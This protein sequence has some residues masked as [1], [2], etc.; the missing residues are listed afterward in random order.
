VHGIGINSSVT[1]A[2]AMSSDATGASAD[3]AKQFTVNDVHKVS[4]ACAAS[5]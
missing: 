1:N 4:D 5:K 2:S 3:T